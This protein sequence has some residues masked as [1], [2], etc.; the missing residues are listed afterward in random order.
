MARLDQYL[1]LD[2]N[3][4][5]AL[6]RSGAPASISDAAEVMVLR[7]DGYET[8]VKGTNGFLCLVERSWGAATAERDFWNAAPVLAVHEIDA[9]KL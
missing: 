6:A 2:E 9:P 3:S 5:I 4:K 8:A 7:R 1:A